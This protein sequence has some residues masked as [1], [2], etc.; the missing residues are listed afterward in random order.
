V[1]H[2]LFAPLRNGEAE[3]Y[4]TDLGSSNAM[5]IVLTC[6]VLEILLFGAP[7]R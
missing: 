1:A 3:S 5:L 4:N 2:V 6:A 7:I